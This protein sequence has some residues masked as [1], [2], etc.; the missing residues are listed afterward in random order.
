V[1][2]WGSNYER[3]NIFVV[4]DL[5]T[6]YVFEKDEVVKQEEKRYVYYVSETIPFYALV[7]EDKISIYYGRDENGNQAVFI[8]IKDFENYN[9]IA[10]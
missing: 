10:R 8:K 7:N 4:L 1:Q 6:E 2:V 5:N 3:I 9:K